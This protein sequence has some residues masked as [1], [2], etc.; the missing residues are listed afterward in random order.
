MTKYW[1]TL[2]LVFVML[3]ILAGLWAVM[4][5]LAI[6]WA[7]QRLLLIREGPYDV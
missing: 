1:Q 5:I 6:A 3:M 2:K 4:P 7:F